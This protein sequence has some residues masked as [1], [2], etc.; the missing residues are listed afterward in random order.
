MIRLVQLAS[1]SALVLLSAACGGGGT[2]DD[3]V[4]D[5]AVVGAYEIYDFLLAYPAFVTEMDD[6]DGAIGNLEL[7]ADGTYELY[8]HLTFNGD[9]TVTWEFGTWE[10]PDFAGAWP[11]RGTLL[12]TPEEGCA[13]PASYGVGSVPGLVDLVYRFEGG[14]PCDPAWLWAEYVWTR[15]ADGS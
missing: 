4:R 11:D 12:L 15:V 8:W 3:P 7:L 9:V 6:Y 10:T 2:P 5:P 14:S 1:L 13:N